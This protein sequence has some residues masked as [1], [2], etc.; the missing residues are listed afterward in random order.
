[1]AKGKNSNT[2][3][4]FIWDFPVVFVIYFFILISQNITLNYAFQ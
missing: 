3:L 4:V 1:M 2:N